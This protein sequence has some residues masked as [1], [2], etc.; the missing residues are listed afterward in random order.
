MRLLTICDTI[1]DR[2]VL[3]A[4]CFTSNCGTGM[5]TSSSDDEDDEEE[6]DDDADC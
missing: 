2:W 6:D 3:V 1:S 5:L 4:T